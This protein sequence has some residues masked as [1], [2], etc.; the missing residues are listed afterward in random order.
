MI[1]LVL[2]IVARKSLINLIIELKELEVP[3]GMK[4][5]AKQHAMHQTN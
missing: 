2:F 5:N 1:L 3:V 4:F